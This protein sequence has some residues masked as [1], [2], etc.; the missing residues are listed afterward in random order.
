M[1]LIKMPVNTDKNKNIR[2]KRSMRIFAD[3]VIF[4]GS[5][6]FAKAPK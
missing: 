4:E 5:M 1:I 2:A 3:I 6:S